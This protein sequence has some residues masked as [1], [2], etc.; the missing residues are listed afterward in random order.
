MTLIMVANCLQS[1]LVSS[2][3]SSL[4][5]FSVFFLCLRVVC[6]GVVWRAVLLCVVAVCVGVCGGCGGS[7]LPAVSLRIAETEQLYQAKRIFGGIGNVLL[8]TY[9]Q[10]EIG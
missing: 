2:L 3:S 10:T 5:S 6:V 8:P 1:C 4:L 7:T 9:S